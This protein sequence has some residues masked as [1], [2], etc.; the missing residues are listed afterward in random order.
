MA[1]PLIQ[2][3]SVCIGY[4]RSVLLENVTFSLPE[5]SICLIKGP[6]G[7]GK[8]TLIK[9]ILGLLPCIKGEITK[10]FKQAAYV[11]Q[12][13]SLDTQYPLTLY[14]LASMGKKPG[15]FFGSKREHKQEV[16]KTLAEVGLSSKE[17]LLFRQASAG[18]LQ[19]ALIARS[20]LTSPELLVLDEPFSNIDQKGKT[21]IVNIIMK[22]HKSYKR[23]AILLIEHQPY[24]NEFYTHILLVEKGRVTL[25]K[26][27]H[28]LVS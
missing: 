14:D 1:R 24:S 18:Q 27:S 5:N 12:N 25:E 2:L 4:Q 8:T 22:D 7:S 20:L 16:F 15:F 26:D 21:D 17:R 23:P 11:P 13:D 3:D 9:T 28:H 6:N 10:N 19:R